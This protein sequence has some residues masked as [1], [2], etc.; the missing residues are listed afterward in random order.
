MQETYSH[1]P[2]ILWY[3]DLN[4]NF[5]LFCVLIAKQE[6]LEDVLL[7]NQ[8]PN[9]K[10]VQQK[11]QGFF[12]TEFGLVWLDPILIRGYP[13]CFVVRWAPSSYKVHLQVEL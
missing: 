7:P 9:F 5:P 13:Q 11:T 2:G 1:I 4:V 6:E 8:H 10:K 3:I 12:Q